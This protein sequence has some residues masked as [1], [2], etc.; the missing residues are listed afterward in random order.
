MAALSNPG[1]RRKTYIFAAILAVLFVA[2]EGKWICI[3]GNVVVLS[4]T[5]QAWAD[6]IDVN[7]PNS[8]TPQ[9]PVEPNFAAYYEPWEFHIKPNIVSYELPLDIGLLT[10]YDRVNEKLGLDR[11]KDLISQNG[12]VIIE[13]DIGSYDPTREDIAKPYEYLRDKGIPMFVTAD[14][15]LHLYHVQFDETLKEIEERQFYDDILIPV[16][17]TH[18]TLPTSD[19]V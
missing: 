13:H 4:I 9:G 1:I 3:D 14:T 16:S 2:V 12:F 19:L 15:L 8:G 17:Y 10:N 5:G 6:P 18:L 7:D 11:A